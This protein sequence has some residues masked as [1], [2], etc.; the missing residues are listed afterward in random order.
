MVL[1]PAV[2]PSSVQSGKTTSL[3]W[4]SLGKLLWAIY[5][6]AKNDSCPVMRADIGPCGSGVI[7]IQAVPAYPIFTGRAA[8]IPDQLFGFSLGV[9]FRFP[10]VSLVFA[11]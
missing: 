9:Q 5:L 2:D 7:F 6:L 1:Y 11:G 8:I 4:P 3:S 10:L